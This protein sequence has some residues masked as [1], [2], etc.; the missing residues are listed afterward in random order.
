MIAVNVNVSGPLFRVAPRAEEVIH[1][2]ANGTIN[3]LVDLGM[4]QL[5][6]MLR[7]RPAGVYLSVQQA[8]K[9]HASVGHYRRMLHQEVRD[10]YGRLD[11]PRPLYPPLP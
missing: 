4:D 1:R 11:H 9:G 6:Q 2:A 3:E 5:S 7:P 10:L 8:Q